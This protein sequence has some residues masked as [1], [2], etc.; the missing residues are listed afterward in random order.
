[1]TIDAQLRRVRRDGKMDDRARARAQELRAQGCT[2]KAISQMLRDEGLADVSY[3]TVWREI[4]ADCD[5][6]EAAVN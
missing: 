4:F 3:A 6:H 5:G 1:V 2:V